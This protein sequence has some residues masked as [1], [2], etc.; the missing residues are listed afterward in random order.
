MTSYEKA[1][2]VMKRE[3]QGHSFD[4][5]LTWHLLNGFVFSRP[6]FFVMGRPVIKW[7][8]PELIVDPSHRFPSGQ[9]DCWH[10]YLLAGLH[11]KAWSVMPWELPWLSWERGNDLRFYEVERIKR[12]SLDPA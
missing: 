11:E 2:Q 4:Y 3:H 5:A 9:C 1:L 6:D 12:L 8:A 7:A 10:I